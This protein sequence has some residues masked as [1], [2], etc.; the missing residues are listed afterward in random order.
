MIHYLIELA[1][2]A[3]L[4]YFVGCLLGWALRNVFARTAAVAVSAAPVAAVIAPKEVTPKVTAPIPAPV[5]HKPAAPAP[6]VAAPVVAAIPIATGKME[7]PT[8]VVM[9]ADGYLAPLV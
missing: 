8:R 9:C 6:V 5:V 3:L 1:I 7:R 4:F 2:W